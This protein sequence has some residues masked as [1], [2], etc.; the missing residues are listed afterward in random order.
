MTAIT[1]EVARRLHY[2]HNLSIEEIDRTGV[3]P[4]PLQTRTL[5]NWGAILADAQ[6]YDYL[7]LVNAILSH[8]PQVTQ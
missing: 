8:Y 1:V 7:K 6:R 5:G 4:Y 3:L 2:Q